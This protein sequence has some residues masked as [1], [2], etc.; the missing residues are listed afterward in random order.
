MELVALQNVVP[1]IKTLGATLVAISPQLPSRNRELVRSRGL[2]FPILS[3]AGNEVAAR[4]GLRFA[5]PDYLR[6]IYASFPLDLATY[7]GDASW[8]LP[9]PARFVID[10]QGIIRAADSDPDYTT[11]PEPEE[12]LGALRALPRR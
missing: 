3:D 6:A 12:T 7:N 11:R 4:F 2:T 10:R 5:L 8:T 9:M 1:E